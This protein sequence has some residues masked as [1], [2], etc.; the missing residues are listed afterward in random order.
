MFRQMR[1]GELYGSDNQMES[2]SFSPENHGIPMSAAI[3]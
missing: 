2:E 3:G 1:V